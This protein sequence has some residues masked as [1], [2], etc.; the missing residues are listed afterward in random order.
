GEPARWDPGDPVE[1]WLADTFLLDAEPADPVEPY[2]A[3]E[4]L[5]RDRM[6]GDVLRDA[7]GLLVAAH[8]R[9]RPS[10]LRRMLD[11]PHLSICAIR[12]LRGLGAVALVA[13]E[14]GLPD[15]LAH[16]IGRGETRPLGHLVP[17]VLACHL[18]RPELATNRGR[19]VVRIAVHAEA[20]RR[21]LGR[22]LVAA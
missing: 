20:R 5:D 16:A 17:E 11:G 2:G 21:G 10:D 12:G 8:Y 6:D 19:R 13:E 15:A 7:F 3:P 1:A 4:P 18:G 22:A 14:G 9:T